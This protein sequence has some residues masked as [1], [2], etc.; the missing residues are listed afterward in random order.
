M[1]EKYKN[2][3][4]HCSK[5]VDD[6][7]SKVAEEEIQNILN[8]I[9]HKA[10]IGGR[11]YTTKPIATSA[12]VMIAQHEVFNNFRVFIH[13]GYKRANDPNCISWY[14]I[15]VHNSNKQLKTFEQLEPFVDLKITW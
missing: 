6:F 9:E 1:E 2:F 5:L 11:E 8:D 3:F 10:R 14:T 13:R 4:A 12:A 15:P 7:Y